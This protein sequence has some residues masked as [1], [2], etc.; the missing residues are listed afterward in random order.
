MEQNAYTIGGYADRYVIIPFEELEALLN[1]AYSNGRMNELLGVE[2]DHT[3]STHEILQ[4]NEDA[5]VI[6]YR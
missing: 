2:H 5:Y 6:E 4:N 3:K 1:V